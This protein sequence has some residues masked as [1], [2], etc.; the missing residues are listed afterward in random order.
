MMD[1]SALSQKIQSEIE[2]LQKQIIS[3]IE[4]QG[5]DRT[6]CFVR[7]DDIGRQ[8]PTVDVSSLSLERMEKRLKALKETWK[9]LQEDPNYG[10]CNSCGQLIPEQR[11]LLLPYVQQ[12]VECA[13]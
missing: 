8:T 9:R 3:F 6:K 5:D 11:L 7:L 4:N 1:K 10:I 13:I 2:S 12:C